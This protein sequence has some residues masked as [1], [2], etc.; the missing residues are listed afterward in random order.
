MSAS[1][2]VRELEVP[3]TTRHPSD[4]RIAD[5]GLICVDPGSIQLR[6]PE[7][8]KVA[9]YLRLEN[10]LFERVADLAQFIGEAVVDADSFPPMG[11]PDVPL[12]VATAARFGIEI[13]PPPGA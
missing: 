11:L 6:Y 1:W 12:L 7:H 2:Q 9:V 8:W 3:A 13:L 4:G 10:V 5:S